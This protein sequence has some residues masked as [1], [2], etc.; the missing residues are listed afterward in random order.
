MR[1]LPTFIN[2][3][4]VLSKPFDKNGNPNIVLSVLATL[5]QGKPLRKEELL[6]KIG[7]KH[8]GKS[9]GYLS[10]VFSA[11]RK[12]EV[13]Q[14]DKRVNQRKWAQ[15]KNYKEYMGFIFM[16]IVDSDPKAAMS[17]AYRLMPKKEEQS[18]DFITSPEED[19]FNRPNPYLEDN[20]EKAE[21]TTVADS[22]L[23]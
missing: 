22:Y 18:L 17:L 20:E 1:Q 15:G 4:K 19:I 11:L 21:S 9:D 7:E 12:L 16:S 6:G 3:D 23:T 13:L 14:F 5:L 8:L 10:N 2:E